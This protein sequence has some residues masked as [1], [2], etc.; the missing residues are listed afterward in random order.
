M[1][2]RTTSGRVRSTSGLD[3][4]AVG[5]LADDLDVVGAAQHEGQSGAHQ[6]IVV[7][8][9]QSDRS[10]G[11]YVITAWAGR[12][13]PWG[14]VARCAR[15]ATPAPVARPPGIRS[16]RTVTPHGSQARTRNAP[17]ASA[18]CSS[19]PPG[20]RRPLG[21]A[22]QALPRAGHVRAPR[23]RARGCARSWSGPRPGAPVDGHRHLGAGGVLAGVGQ[24]LLGDAVGGAADGRR[25]RRRGRRR[26]CR[27]R[28][29][30]P[31]RGTRRP[32]CPARRAS[33]GGGPRRRASPA[34]RTPMISR[35]SCSASCALSRMTPAARAISARGASGRNSR[36]PA[37]TLSRV[38]RCARTSCISRAMSSRASRWAC[39]ARSARLVLG[40]ARRGRAG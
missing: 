14:P 25:A 33:A 19:R 27:G 32:A 35:R 29:S 12:N 22:D 34:R 38:R 13:H 30:C 24:A 6:R 2:I 3:L 7:D 16:G 31:P 1:S 15:A 4:G 37:C 28:P 40:A 11:A 26:G 39:S 17:S 20:Q 36:A 10:H 23:P 18:P 9:E 5:R 21:E 8:E